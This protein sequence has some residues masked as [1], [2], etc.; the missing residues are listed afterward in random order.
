M[1][2][3]AAALV[4]P[5]DAEDATQEALERA[6]R[7]WPLLRDPEALHPWLLRITANVCHDWQRGRFGAERRHSERLP[8]ADDSISAQLG[9]LSADVGSYQHAAALDLRRAINGLPTDLRLAVVLRY[10]AGLDAAEISRVTDANA[11][12]VRTRLQR[13]LVLL[14]DQLGG[15]IHSLEVGLDAGG[16]A[17]ACNEQHASERNRER[18]GERS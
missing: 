3:L 2:R 4:G 9:W 10:Y 1:V 6:W 17:T 12:T 5:A 18:S 14:R 8:D 11:S 16:G 15:S 7:A 13:A